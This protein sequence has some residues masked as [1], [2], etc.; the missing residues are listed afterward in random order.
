MKINKKEDTETYNSSLIRETF[1][2]NRCKLGIAIFLNYFI[3]TK[4]NNKC[5]IVLKCTC[6]GLQKIISESE[7]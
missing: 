5:Y 7:R 2:E 4:A 6:K 3:K 1:Q